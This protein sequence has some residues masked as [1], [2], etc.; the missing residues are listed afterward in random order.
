[1]TNTDAGANAGSECTPIA[2]DQPS[3]K[4]PISPAARKFAEYLARRM[5]PMIE[6][7]AKR[8]ETTQQANDAVAVHKQT[9]RG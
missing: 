2:S 9:K 8:N 7:A 4:P 5:A 6:R 1:M 3:S